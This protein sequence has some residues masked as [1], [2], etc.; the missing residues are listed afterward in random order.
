MS[1]PP[2][3]Q[4]LLLTENGSLHTRLQTSENGDNCREHLQIEYS[5]SISAAVLHQNSTDHETARINHDVPRNS[6]FSFA[7]L[8]YAAFIIVFVCVGHASYE[9]TPDNA[10]IFRSCNA[11]TYYMYAVGIVFLLYINLFVIHPSWFNWI[12]RRFSS[13][14]SLTPAS[15][16]ARA[17]NSL[18]LR[19]GIL[20]FGG[21]G[22][23]LFALLLFLLISGKIE[24]ILVDTATIEA[25]LGFVFTFYQMYFMNVNYKVCVL[26][27]SCTRYVIFQ[28]QIRSSKDVCQFGFMH[29]L[30]VNVWTWYRFV[31]AKFHESVLKFSMRRSSRTRLPRRTLW[32]SCSRTSKTKILVLNGLCTIQDRCACHG[33]TKADTPIR[34]QFSYT[35]PGIFGGVVLAIA[36]VFTAA[37]YEAVEHEGYGTAAFGAFDSLCYGLCIVAVVAASSA[38]R[39]MAVS[40]SLHSDEVDEILL[41]VAFV[42]EVVW[43]SAELANFLTGQVGL[44][45]GVLVLAFTLLRLVHVFTQTWFILAATRMRLSRNPTLR[46][47]RGR[48]PVTFLLT[49]NIILFFF[50][51]FESSNDRFGI[52]N[53]LA[54][55]QGYL[56]LAAAPII[57]F[58]RFHCAVCLAEIW[59]R[60]FARP[61][62]PSIEVTSPGCDRSTFTIVSMD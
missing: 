52:M 10:H 48:I 11:L 27:R 61:K 50:S 62:D 35:L 14:Y 58:Y 7:T 46:E 17:V 23:V 41:Y 55:T 34:F 44:D 45:Q 38:M 5:R 32:K 4:H 60:S 29:L 49:V 33:T 1:A 56:K 42:G 22:S 6:S 43:N 59:Q 21:A 3:P 26:L 40:S 18:F 51:I 47:L 31:A 53:E 19:L 2:V 13:N 37:I 8:L 28:L 20:L 57:I 9:V 24:A 15:Q 25:A 12:L 30:A 39:S 54:S 36:G 16:D